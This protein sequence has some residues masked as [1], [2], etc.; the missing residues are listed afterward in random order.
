MISHSTSS[1]VAVPH[2]LLWELCDAVL[3]SR[4]VREDVRRHVC[5][6]IVQT[7]LR[8]VDSHGI[9][10]FPHYVEAVD[11]GRI[12]PNPAY[13]FEQTGASTGR[14]N[15][16]NAFGHAAGGEAML[17]AMAMA[18]NSGMGAVAVFNSTHFGA[19]AYFSLL[20]SHADLIGM[21]FT[22]STPHMLTYGGVRTFF[23]TNPICFSAPCEGEEPFC[24]DMATSLSTWNRIRRLGAEGSS[25]PPDW[26]CDAAGNP[27]TE[28][29]KV[30]TLLPIG[31]YKGFGLAMM[32]DILCG[33]LT[34][35]P[36]GSAISSMYDVPIGQKRHLGHFFMA[37]DIGRFTEVATFKRRL[38]EMMDAVRSEP[39]KDPDTP[40]LVAGDPEKIACA[41]RAKSGIPLP[42]ETYERLLTLAREVGFTMPM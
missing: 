5:D 13:A 7:S 39:R 12:N 9:E 42:K 28:P 20:A 38:K 31:G 16:D 27:T 1:T 17:K 33:L 14:L 18:R 4:S 34:G 11:G 19:A 32:V 21:S 26:G 29:D 41:E 25:I 10:L 30:A 2:R 8:A 3:R 15:A 24:L 37:M 36:F 23:S 22:H 6:A 40:I 35:M